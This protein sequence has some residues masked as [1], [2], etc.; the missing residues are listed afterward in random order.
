MLVASFYLVNIIDFAV[1]TQDAK[2]SALKAEV[3]LPAIASFK[4][5]TRAAIEEIE[6]FTDLEKTCLIGDVEDAWSR[7]EA[8]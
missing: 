6:V 2:L 7:L 1:E 5:A 4:L 3:L 8:G